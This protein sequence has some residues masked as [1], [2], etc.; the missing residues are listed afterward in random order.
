LF[1]GGAYKNAKFGGFTGRITFPEGKDKFISPSLYL[2]TPDTRGFGVGA[3]AKIVIGDNASVETWKA[4]GAYK[5]IGLSS[6]LGFETKADRP[7]PKP[8]DAKPVVKAD[9]KPAE[10]VASKPA[11]VPA[12]TYSLYLVGGLLKNCTKDVNKQFGVNGAFNITKSSLDLEFL[13]R[14]NYENGTFVKVKANIEGNVGVSKQFKPQNG[15][16][17]V[18]GTNVNAF[19]GKGN[20]GFQF[21]TDL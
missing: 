14:K 17:I 10:K 8:E 11:Q 6:F 16:S 19:T 20:A 1:L 5:K 7:E 2:E 18:L 4:L 12:P 13:F 21:S 9:N 15:T 3:N